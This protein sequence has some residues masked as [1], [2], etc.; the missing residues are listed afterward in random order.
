MVVVKYVAFVGR[1]DVA[2]VDVVP[3]LDMFPPFNDFLSISPESEDLKA[4]HEQ[5]RVCTADRVPACM[6]EKKAV[7]VLGLRQKPFHLGGE[8]IDIAHRQRAEVRKKG[9]VLE[10]IVY[11]EVKPILILIGLWFGIRSESVQSP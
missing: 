9:V 2:C 10:L 7:L 6:V 5:R 4:A 1:L 8:D 11:V 3:E